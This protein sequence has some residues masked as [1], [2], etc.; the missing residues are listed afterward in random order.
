[1]PVQGGET[2]RHRAPQSLS[3]RRRCERHGKPSDL[4][5]WS[6]RDGGA[7][8]RGEQ[9]ASQA[10]TEQRFASPERLL[11]E[12][13][14]VLQERILV[15]F[16]DAHRP[17]HHHEASVPVQGT[18]HWLLLECTDVLDGDALGCE[19]VSNQTRR[20]TRDVLD[21]ADGLLGHGALGWRWIGV[22][23]EQCLGRLA[24][25]RSTVSVGS[26]AASHLQRAEKILLQIFDVLDTHRHTHQAV[27]DAGALAFLAAHLAMGST[28]GDAD[29]AFH[30]AQA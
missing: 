20:F 25:R 21:G 22:G 7:E 19:D 17:A 8:R 3:R 30:A 6:A 15:L 27:A 23:L 5:S 1:M 26:A 14:F 18:W 28:A 13:D 4:L 29:E 24:S 12:P 11:N 2:W 9:L 10:D 16:I